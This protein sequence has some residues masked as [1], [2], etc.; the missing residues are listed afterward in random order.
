[1]PLDT[2]P[3]WKTF[4]LMSKWFTLMSRW[5]SPNT[6]AI[7]QP[8]DL[9]VIASFKAF[10]L[11]RTIAMALQATTLY[12][13][14]LYCYRA[15]TVY[16]SCLYRLPQLP[17]L[18]QLLHHLINIYFNPCGIKLFSLFLIKYIFYIIFT[19]Y[20]RTILYSTVRIE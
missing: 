14:C 5:L 20:Y 9:G 8:M 17:L 1:M 11:R 7:L 10:Y 12:I 4:T 15:S 2:L 18:F 19:F 6:T 16:L 3:S 13:S